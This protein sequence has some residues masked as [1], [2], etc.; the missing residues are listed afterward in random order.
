MT[1][2]DGSTHDVKADLPFFAGAWMFVVL[3]AWAQWT[4]IGCCTHS[5]RLE[6]REQAEQTEQRV[7]RVQMLLTLQL[8][9]TAQTTLVV[10]WGHHDVGVFDAAAPQ[11]P[12]GETV[13]HWSDSDDYLVLI[14]EWSVV[15]CLGRFQDY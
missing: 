3:Q 9:Q 5:V 6:Q 7:Q 4:K 8:V 2:E 12:L 13:S 15:M 14:Q 1:L 10:H 11:H